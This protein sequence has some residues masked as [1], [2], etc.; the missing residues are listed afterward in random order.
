M[1]A[2]KDPSLAYEGIVRDSEDLMPASEAHLCFRESSAGLC[3]PTPAH[4]GI[5][6]SQIDL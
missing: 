3:G 6:G 2:C 5:L 1:L 4:A